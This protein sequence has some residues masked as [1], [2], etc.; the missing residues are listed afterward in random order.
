MKVTS[1][2]VG[3]KGDGTGKKKLFDATEVQDADEDEITASNTTLSSSANGS[4]DNFI[5]ILTSL[6][7]STVTN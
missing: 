2:F 1:F 6:L 5:K 3:G 4:S 7:D